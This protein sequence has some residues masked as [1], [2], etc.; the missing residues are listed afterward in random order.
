MGRGH[1]SPN[2][3]TMNLHCKALSYFFISVVPFPPIH[4]GIYLLKLNISKKGT[5]MIKGSWGTQNYRQRAS[6]NAI[7]YDSHDACF[8]SDARPFSDRCYATVSLP[9]DLG[10]SKSRGA[11]KTPALY[12][13]YSGLLGSP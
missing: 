7:Y 12:G 10:V 9:D 2:L 3:G 8:L 5:V 6:Q 1:N 13:E 11:P 4:S